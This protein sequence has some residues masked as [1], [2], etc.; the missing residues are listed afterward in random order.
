MKGT[1][2]WFNAKKVSD[3][4]PMKKEMTYSYTFLLCRWTDSKFSMKATK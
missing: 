1:V 2:K 4:S 3:L